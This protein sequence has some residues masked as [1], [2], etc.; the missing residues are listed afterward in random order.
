MQSPFFATA[1]VGPLSRIFLIL[2][3]IAGFIRKRIAIL[4]RKI[5]EVHKKWAGLI[6]GSGRGFGKQ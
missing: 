6:C 1:I 3:A 4:Y 5:N 2:D